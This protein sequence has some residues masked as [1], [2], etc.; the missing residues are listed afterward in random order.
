MATLAP[1]ERTH[2]QDAKAF[3]RERGIPFP[4]NPAYEE[5]RLPDSLDGLSPG[6]VTEE[7]LKWTR[8][9]AYTKAEL[10]LCEIRHAEAKDTYDK[11][12][13]IE[14]MRLRADNARSTVKDLYAIIDT[15]QRFERM[16]RKVLV[17]DA[18]RK[19]MQSVHDGQD[20]CYKLLSRELTRRTSSFGDRNL[21]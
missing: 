10:S 15:N 16:G 8:T 17:L 7:M 21:D 2:A 6:D 11:R 5:L 12:R 13:Q 3:L 18:R 9:L 14:F 20:Q 19:L 4:E 1:K